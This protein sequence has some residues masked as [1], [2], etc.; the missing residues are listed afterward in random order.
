M[1]TTE[2]N[3]AMQSKLAALGVPFE[4]LVVFGRIRQNVHVKCV[5]HDTASKWASVLSQVFKGAKVTTVGT[6]W[7]A[8]E[9]KGTNLRPTMRSGFLVAVAA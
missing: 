1:N 5:S 2:L 8:A 9:N 4:T 6:V 7:E 3:A